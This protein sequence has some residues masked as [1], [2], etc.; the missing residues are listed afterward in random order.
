[1]A[2]PRYCVPFPAT[3]SNPSKA[4]CQPSHRA[5]PTKVN[6]SREEAKLETE[7]LMTRR[8]GTPGPAFLRKAR[9]LDAWAQLREQVG[10]FEVGEGVL[11]T[12]GQ[13]A[14]ERRELASHGS[15]LL[16]QQGQ[17]LQ[18]VLAQVEVE[19]GSKALGGIHQPILGDSSYPGTQGQVSCQPP[20]A[21]RPSRPPWCPWPAA[22][23]N[24]HGSW[25]TWICVPQKSP[26]H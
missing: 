25:P 6:S 16:R 8:A 9:R 15:R 12:I 1:M 19:E 13:F 3:V 10:D 5:L 22:S 4:G 26:W 20:A 24:R 23:S 7:Y 11:K 17:V 21:G 14:C 18:D 2:S